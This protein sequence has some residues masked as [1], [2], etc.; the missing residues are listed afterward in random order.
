MFNLGKLFGGNKP[1]KKATSAKKSGYFLQLDEEATAA[2]PTPQ[3]SQ[4]FVET[5]KEAAKVTTE[6]RQPVQQATPPATV[7]QEKIPTAVER[8]TTV[9]TTAT[10]TN[11]QSVILAPK[12]L[13]PTTSR[14][15]RRPGPSLAM[16]KDMARQVNKTNS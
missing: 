12:Y 1:G 10:G 3:P 14:P 7:L 16:F 8:T 13:Q 5:P 9:T 6:D 15:R 11:G 4:P 2:N